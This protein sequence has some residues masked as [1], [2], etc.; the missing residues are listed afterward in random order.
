MAIMADIERIIVVVQRVLISFMYKWN[1]ILHT[2]FL[3]L[4]ILCK[5]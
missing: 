4:R 3:S 5:R 2:Y 1:L